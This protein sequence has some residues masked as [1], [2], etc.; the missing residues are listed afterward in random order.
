MKKIICI[1]FAYEAKMNSG[2]NVSNK[3]DKTL[4]YLQNA[5]VALCSAKHYNKDCDVVF[6]TNMSLEQIPM[7]IQNIFLENGIR[8][9]NIQFDRY[10]F[11][12]NYQWSLA[13]YKLCVLSHIVE[14]GWD[15]ICYMDTDVYVQNSFEAVWQEC[16]LNILLYD[17]NHGL[18]TEEYIAIND[19]FTN[20]LGSNS[21]PTH[22]GGEFFAASREN[23]KQFEMAAVKVYKEMIDRT[24]VTTKGDEFIVSLVAKQMI[25]KVKNA[26]P[27]IHRFWTGANFRLTSTCY[28]Y[29]SVIVLH[30]PAEKEKGIITLYKRYFVKKKFP[31]DRIVWKICRLSY[32]PFYYKIGAWIM[33]IIRKT[34]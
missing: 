30:M 7:E 32:Q 4:L 31:T 13:F 24:F 21:L 11:P 15:Y 2:V 5:T 10:R 8:I 14:D 18:N 23:A 3:T 29:N 17:I 16:A 9:L 27:Y 6:A 28:K 22:Y 26:S 1:P 34:N 25:D 12:D 20:F 33:N 19:E